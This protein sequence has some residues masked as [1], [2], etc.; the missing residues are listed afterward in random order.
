MNVAITPTTTLA[1]STG[2]IDQHFLR[3]NVKPKLEWPDED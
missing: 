2:T 1:R 3:Y